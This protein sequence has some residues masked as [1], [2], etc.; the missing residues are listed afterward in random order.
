MRTHRITFI[1]VIATSIIV[2][3][4]VAV[5]MA[6]DLP[7]ASFSPDGIV[8]GTTPL[9]TM[10]L[11]KSIPNEEITKVR[12]A[13][14]DVAVQKSEGKLIFQIPKL[15][16]VGTAYVEVIG[17]GDK[18][19]AVGQIKYVEPTERSSKGLW[20]LILIYVVLVAVP[21]TAFTLYDIRK[22]YKERETVL[23][24]LSASTTVDDRKAILAAMDQGPTGFTGLTRGIVAVTLILVVAIAIFHIVVF[25]TISSNI[26]EQLLT[27]LAGSVTSIIGFYFGSKTATEAAKPTQPSAG[28]TGGSIPP[29]ILAL[30]PPDKVAIKGKLTITGEGFGKQKGKS[31]VQ[32]NDKEGKV[33]QS[34]WTN[35][36]IVVTVPSGMTVGKGVNV[37]VTNDEGTPSEPK[38]IEITSEGLL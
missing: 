36:Q 33:E 34:D 2:A 35:K 38:Q 9:I 15:D 6:A 12:V 7:R 25:G 5:V 32:F 22:S 21:P 29:K 11:D 13:E 31:A 17:K 19:V 8:R 24:D 3:V 28:K 37:V 10:T 4:A 20:V 18:S 27:L 14:H 26:A 1:A 16:I 30:D 23:K